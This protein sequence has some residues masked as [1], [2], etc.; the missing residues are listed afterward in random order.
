[1]SFLVIIPTCIQGDLGPCEQAIQTPGPHT[2]S[3]SLPSPLHT[4]PGHPDSPGSL[5]S[6]RPGT[7]LCPGSH[8]SD[9]MSWLPAPLLDLIWASSSRSFCFLFQ[10]FLH[11]HVCPPGL[12]QQLLTLSKSHVLS[13]NSLR[14]E[15]SFPDCSITH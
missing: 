13:F 14:R 5:A 15:V 6:L 12:D 2:L 8:Y 4:R 10:H 1:M 9:H 3:S 11:L 7:R